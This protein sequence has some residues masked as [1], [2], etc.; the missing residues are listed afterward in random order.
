[1]LKFIDSRTNVPLR[2][3]NNIVAVYCSIRIIIEVRETKN[4]INGLEKT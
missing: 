2:I 1:M 3:N 4:R